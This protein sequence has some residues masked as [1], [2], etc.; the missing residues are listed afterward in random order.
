M[1]IYIHTLC[2]Y[3][4]VCIMCVY[5]IYTY[6]MYIYTYICMYIHMCI[7]ICIYISFF[8][9]HSFIDGHLDCFHILAVVNNA[10]M[11]IGV[12]LSFWISVFFWGGVE[13]L[14]HIV[15]L[16]LVFWETSILFSIVAIS[17]RIPTN[18]SIFSTSLSTFAI[19][20]LFDDSYSD[21]CKVLSPYGFDL[22]FPDD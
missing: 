9:I 4:Y 8:F 16:L 1:Y 2:V 14:G 13:L 3:T 21:R 22:H 10:A 12:N 11:N 7:H 18:S 20:I 15:V 17:I 6:I 5:I 19:C